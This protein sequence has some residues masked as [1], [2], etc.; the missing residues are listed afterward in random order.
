[1]LNICDTTH[2]MCGT[3]TV[4]Q[5]S[6][7]SNAS[8]LIPKRLLH[9]SSD[10]TSLQVRL[11]ETA[12]G[13]SSLKA[14]DLQYTALS[15]CWG[16]IPVISTTIA[17]ISEFETEGIAWASLPKTFQEAIILTHELGIHYIWIDSLCK[18][19]RTPRHSIVCTKIR[20]HDRHST[21]LRL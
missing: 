18:H 4:K 19:L 5:S 14:V 8:K 17:T 16:S 2:T 7:G 15:H 12:S 20:H 1:M 10:H 6:S 21:G 3:N 9:I 13:D 11:F